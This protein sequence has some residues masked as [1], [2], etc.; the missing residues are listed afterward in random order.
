MGTLIVMAT[1]SLAPRAGAT[2]G[3]LYTQI[4][5]HRTIGASGVWA[6]VGPRDP[7]RGKY[8]Y[9]LRQHNCFYLYLS[10]SGTRRNK[11]AFAV[12]LTAVEIC[13]VKE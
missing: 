4:K 12:A 13:D 1:H 8:L 11:P 9:L 3:R 10:K 2:G 6:V 5:A 7:Q